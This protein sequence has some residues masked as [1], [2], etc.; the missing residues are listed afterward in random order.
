ML[1]QLIFSYRRV[2]IISYPVGTTGIVR[3][4]AK[5][6]NKKLFSKFAKASIIQNKNLEVV[7]SVY[8]AD[9]EALG[10]LGFAYIIVGNLSAAQMNLT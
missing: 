4:E 2:G 8:P 10:N 1:S 9:A 3:A 5:D 6:P 7:K